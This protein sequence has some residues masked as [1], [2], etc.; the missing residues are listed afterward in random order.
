MHEWVVIRVAVILGMTCALA[1]A[2]PRRAPSEVL[3]QA[4]TAARKTILAKA[5][6]GTLENVKRTIEDGEVVYEVDF[7]KGQ[8]ERSFTVAHDGALLHWQVFMRELPAPAQAMVRSQ[9]GNSQLVDIFWTDDIGE[10]SYEV[11]VARNGKSHSFSVAPN[12]QLLSLQVSLAEAPEP[13]RKTIQARV[14]NGTID[15][16]YWAI[17]D[18]EVIYVVETTQNG[19]EHSFSVGADGEF[20][21]STVALSE[22]PVPVQ[23]AIKRQLGDGRL[24]EIERSEDGSEVS[25]EVK[26]LRNGRR[27]CFSLAVDGKIIS[28]QVLLAETPAE[29]RDAIQKEIRGGRIIRI[30]QTTDGG[31]SAYEVEAK[32]GGKRISFAINAAGKIEGGK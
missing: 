3:A 4:S 5:G 21:S 9:L 6:N 11:E 19:K 17:E 24:G 7:K 12:G 1:S 20:L 23:N 18:E 16:L 2:A 13:V 32:K 15:D 29:V 14:G 26:T 22:T 8:V 30:D 28:Q 25:F 31:E 27:R 10:I